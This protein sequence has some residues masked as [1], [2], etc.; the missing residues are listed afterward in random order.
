MSTKAKKRKA[1]TVVVL[2]FVIMTISLSVA[3]MIRSAQVETQT[4]IEVRA[5]V[6]IPAENKLGGI[7]FAVSGRWGYD[8]N[9]RIIFHAYFDQGLELNKVVCLI[10]HN[11]KYIERD[12]RE[13]DPT[14]ITWLERYQEVLTE[15][16][17]GERKTQTP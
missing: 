12:Y 9:D 3:I 13:W 2:I 15:A 5:M 14:W 8:K 1:R 10:Y 16:T 7:E 6:G 11:G 17:T 4:D